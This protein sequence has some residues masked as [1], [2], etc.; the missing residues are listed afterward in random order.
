MGSGAAMAEQGAGTTGENR[1]EPAPIRSELAVPDGVHGAIYAMEPPGNHPRAY[2]APAHSQP[3]QLP[4]RHQPVL[5][6][7]HPRDP[8]IWSI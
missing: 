4:V 7:R 8:H 3:G 6:V 5:P 1:C 2:S